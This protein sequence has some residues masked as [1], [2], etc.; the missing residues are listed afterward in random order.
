MKINTEPDPVPF[1]E[2]TNDD[3]FWKGHED[4]RNHDIQEHTRRCYCVR[5][6]MFY[7]P[8]KRPND[9][10]NMNINNSKITNNAMEEKK[11]IVVTFSGG[12]DTS[13]TVMYL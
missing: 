11:K 9:Q 5:T 2:L 13:F 8:V 7:D 4:C 12:L 3:A 1:A 10:I 6:A